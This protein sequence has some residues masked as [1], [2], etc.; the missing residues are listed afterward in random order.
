MS[1]KPT[2][3]DSDL[4]GQVVID[5]SLQ[6]A[7]GFFTGVGQINK[8]GANDAI[9][10]GTE[11][12]IWDGGG[13]YS[14][15]STPDITHIHALVDAAADRSAVIEVQGL[16]TLWAPVTQTKALDGTNS[17]TLVALDT[18]LKR[19]FR[20]RVNDNVT[21]SQNVE[22]TNAGDTTQYALMQAGN[23][24][25]LMAIYTVPAGK[26]AYITNYYWSVTESTGKQPISTEFRVWFA[27]RANDYNFQ[28]KHATG[29]PLAGP[30]DKH[31]FN[32]YLVATEKTDIKMT[33][34]PVGEIG[35]VHGGFDVI[36]VDN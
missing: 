23:N 9:A 6:I 33:A 4:G 30:G 18:A 19:V 3:T 27:D 21:L 11:E 15:P 12:D 32:P 14:F 24:Q 5:P 10:A 31:L 22:A 28:L 34:A 17:T 16:D 25:T 36:L 26:T 2:V 7:R 29:V 8:F 13:T 1:Y 35:D 20:M